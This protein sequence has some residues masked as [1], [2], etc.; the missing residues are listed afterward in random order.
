MAII[1]P[2]RALRP[3]AELASRVASLPYDVMNT[4]EA[5]EMASGNL[6]SFLHVSRAEIDLPMGTD[7]HSPIVYQRAAVEL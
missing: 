3:T 6:Y 7:V 2:F 1:K 4:E 5:R